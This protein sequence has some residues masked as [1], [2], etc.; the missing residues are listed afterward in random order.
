[1]TGLICSVA[2]VGGVAA[3]AHQELLAG[4]MSAEEVSERRD[5]KDRSTIRTGITGPSRMP[6]HQAGCGDYGN[7]Q[8]EQCANCQL[9][10]YD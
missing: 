4:R 5:L 2:P 6:D 8:E 10:F 1:M 9:V 3:R 7:N